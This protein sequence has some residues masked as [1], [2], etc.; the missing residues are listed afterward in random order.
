MSLALIVILLAIWFD[1]ITNAQ[2]YSGGHL[3]LL[4][5]VAALLLD[6][7]LARNRQSSFSLSNDVTRRMLARL[8]PEE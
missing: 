3:F 8:Y 4:L 1:A 6:F 7:A 5:A 2:E